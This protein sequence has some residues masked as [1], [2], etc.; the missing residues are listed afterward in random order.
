MSAALTGALKAQRHLKGSRVLYSDD[1][2]AA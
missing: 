1:G 2:S